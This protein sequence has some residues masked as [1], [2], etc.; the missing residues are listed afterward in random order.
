MKNTALFK[1]F[2]KTLETGLSVS[3]ISKNLHKTFWDATRK[4]ENKNLS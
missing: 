4:C 1:T 3:S 2:G